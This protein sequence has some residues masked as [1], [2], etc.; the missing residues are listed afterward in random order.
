MQLFRIAVLL[1]GVVGTHARG[2]KMT[3]E[4][5]HM[6]NGAYDDAARA[7]GARE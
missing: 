3:E 7:A 6:A 2:K 5:E 4:E 1:L